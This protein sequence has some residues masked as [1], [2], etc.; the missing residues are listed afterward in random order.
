MND[1]GHGSRSLMVLCFTREVQRFAPLLLTFHDQRK[2]KF[3]FVL[4][5]TFE[6]EISMFWP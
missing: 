6:T 1:C 2:I 4:I 5:L 3:R